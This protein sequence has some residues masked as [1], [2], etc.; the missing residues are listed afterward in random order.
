MPSSTSFGSRSRCWMI[1]RYSSR[2]SAT[3]RS[4]RSSNWIIGRDFPYARMLRPASSPPRYAYPGT[5]SGKRRSRS[6][7]LPPPRMGRVGVGGNQSSAFPS[8][9]I[10]YFSALSCADEFP[11]SLYHRLEEQ[12][13]V[14]SAQGGFGAAL[15]V[16]H[17]THDIAPPVDDAGDVV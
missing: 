12:P 7:L 10:G 3:S 13:A 17:H 6:P 5:L 1:W 4:L 11:G 9:S 8:G 15:R 2:V 16:G 14:F